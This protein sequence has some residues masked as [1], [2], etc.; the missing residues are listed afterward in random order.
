[1]SGDQITAALIV[2]GYFA[3]GAFALWAVDTLTRRW[4]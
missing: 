3:A 2:A 4:P 1:M